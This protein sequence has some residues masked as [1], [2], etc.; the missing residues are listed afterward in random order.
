MT[1]KFLCLFIQ[2][3]FEGHPS[4]FSHQPATFEAEASLAVEFG[5]MAAFP[6]R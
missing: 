4:V 5:P 1:W 6:A 2:C 3:F